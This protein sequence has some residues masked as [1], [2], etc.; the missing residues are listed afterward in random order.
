MQKHNVARDASIYNNLVHIAIASG[1]LSVMRE[2]LNEQKAAGIRMLVRF[3]FYA[4]LVQFVFEFF[5]FLEHLTREQR[6][7]LMR[8]HAAGLQVKDTALLQ[9]VREQMEDNSMNGT[10]SHSLFEKYAVTFVVFYPFC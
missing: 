6:K 4:E 7:M 8:V 3:L 5:P 1:N 9:F 2:L 10:L